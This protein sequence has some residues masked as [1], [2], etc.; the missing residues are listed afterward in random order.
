M[1][2]DSVTKSAQG[3]SSQITRLA[4]YVLLDVQ[5]AGGRFF[6]VP[7]PVQL[8]HLFETTFNEDVGLPTSMQ[9]LTKANTPKIGALVIKRFL[10]TPPRKR[11]H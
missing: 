9:Q 11:K 1:N 6:C 8:A 2:A 7:E 5:R 3:R 4:R 10:L